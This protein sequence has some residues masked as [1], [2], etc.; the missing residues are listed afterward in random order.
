MSDK[1][2]MEL[3]EQQAKVL[4]EPMP[5]VWLKPMLREELERI[6]L[7]L[8]RYTCPVYKTSE[9]RGVLSTTGHSTNFVLAMFL[10]TSVQP[11]HW[12]KRGAALLCQL[13]D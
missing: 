3:G 2:R 10:K 13:D 6:S 5:I 11:S 7:T 4:N 1:K 8:N 9:R 12:V